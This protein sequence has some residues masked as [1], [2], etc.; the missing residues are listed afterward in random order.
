[1]LNIKDT[2]IALVLSFALGAFAA[3]QV[4]DTMWSARDLEQ[5]LDAAKMVQKATAKTL[6]S[7]RKNAELAQTLEVNHVQSQQ[8]LD[9][10][11]ADN[12]RLARELGGLRD[13]GRRP[14]PEGS[15]ASSEL[16]CGAA[17]A[18]LSDEATEFLLGFAH[19]ADQVA[20][21][22]ETC[23]TWIERVRGL[24]K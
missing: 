1:M 24:D 13:P 23:H 21:Y 18:Q 3:W 16:A 14:V 11:L 8:Q 10:A 2:P 22:A 17:P 19:D 6:E 4:T 15:N 9:K 12:R 7:E 20:Q 5:K